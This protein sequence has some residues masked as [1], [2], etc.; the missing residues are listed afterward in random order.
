MRA[1]NLGGDLSLADLTG[2]DVPLV[3]DLLLSLLEV[4]DRK[5]ERREEGSFSRLSASA[6]TTGIALLVSVMVVQRLS[7]EPADAELI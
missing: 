6:S 4:R 1:V 3:I 2:V 7:K 5:R